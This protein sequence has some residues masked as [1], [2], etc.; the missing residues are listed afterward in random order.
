V[1]SLAE[2][3]LCL[4][5]RDAAHRAGEHLPAVAL[6][7]Q[8]LPALRGQAVQPPPALAGFLRPP[9]FDPLALLEPVEQGLERGDVEPQRPVRSRLDQLAD[10][11]PMP[12][13]VLDQG[14]DEQ[15]GA[16]FLEFPGGKPSKHMS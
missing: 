16:A 11:V 15:L 3:A 4:D 8:H 12:G 5:T 14:E 2:R 6:L 1:P 9:P 10:V 13:P 7:G